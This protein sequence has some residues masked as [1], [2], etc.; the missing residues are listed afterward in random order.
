MKKETGNR[1][2][3]I[4]PKIRR[5]YRILIV[6]ESTLSRVCTMRGGWL[7]ICLA[8]ALLLGAGIGI[9]MLIVGFTP[10]KRSVPGFMTGDDRAATLQALTRIDSLQ[11]ELHTN[12]AFLDN[13][14]RLLDTDREPTDSLE[15]SG[16]PTSDLPLDSLI[17]SSARERKF[18]AMM[19]ENEKYN[20]KVLAPIAAEGMIWSDPVAGA[21][22]QEQTR[23]LPLLKLI[24]P[25]GR[26]VSAMADGRVIDRSYDPATRSYALILQHAHGFMTRYSNLGRPLVDKGAHVLASQILT[27]ARTEADN[28]IGIEM[29]RD[30]TPLLPADYAYRSLPAMPDQSIEAPRGK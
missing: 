18:V 6:D 8:G 22:V 16:K 29:W 12:Q 5:R 26:G 19:D 2:R 11:G 17:G 3:R 23:T 28:T 30:G 14:S 24:V 21:I 20:L 7:R 9:G 15:S 13:I 10:V 25:R 27:E 1:S 4:F